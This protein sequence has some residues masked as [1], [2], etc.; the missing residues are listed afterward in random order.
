MFLNV[1]MNIVY[2]VACLV[3]NY[4]VDYYQGFA[5]KINGLLRRSSNLRLK[6][7]L[8]V[9]VHDICCLSDFESLWEM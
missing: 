3:T 4:G 1:F 7:K 5:K 9:V 6:F 2:F 8:Y